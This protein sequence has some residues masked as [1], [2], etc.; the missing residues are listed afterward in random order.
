MKRGADNAYRARSQTPPLLWRWSGK[1]YLGAAHGF[2]GI[3]YMLLHVETLLADTESKQKL[4][5]TMEWIM[6]QRL[7][8]GN[9]PTYR[10]GKIDYLMDF[11]NGA[12]GAVHL[13]C[14][15]YE[16]LGESRYLYAAE[17]AAL[18]VWQHGLVKKGAGLCH[19]MAGNGYCFLA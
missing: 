15:A 13:F 18:D 7:G 2:M 6:D 5:V 4:I 16:V 10:D 1:E 11:C 12:P 8:N 17:T 19:G 3:V 14:K 9:W